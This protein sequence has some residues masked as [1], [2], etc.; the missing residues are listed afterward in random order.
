MKKIIIPLILITLGAGS[1]YI[2]RQGGA[3]KTVPDIQ[4]TTA[5]P[6]LKSAESYGRTSRMAYD[7]FYRD[8]YENAPVAFLIHGGSNGSG[9][10][11]TLEPMVDMYTDLGFAA[12][13]VEYRTGRQNALVDIPC[14]VSHFSLQA[15]EFGV[16]PE[17]SII[18]GFSFGGNNSSNIVFTDNYD[19]TSSCSV[20][21]NDSEVL[22]FIGHSANNLGHQGPRGAFDKISKNDPPTLLLF[23]AD[24]PDLNPSEPQSFI[25]RLYEKGIDGQLEIIDGIGH[26]PS[27]HLQNAEITSIIQE[28][29]MDILNEYANIID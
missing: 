3:E 2:L 19:W 13:L 27:G 29:S 12:V 1:L 28:F 26:G 11:E 4:L 7:V 25:D 6:V 18:H 20:D 21:Q 8:S 24:D 17:A 9:V 16:N 15:E 5:G 23:G 10:K 22:A 14:A